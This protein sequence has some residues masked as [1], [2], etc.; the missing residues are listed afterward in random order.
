ME[1]NSATNATS[2]FGMKYTNR[3]LKY[4]KKLIPVALKEGGHEST[5][6]AIKLLQSAKLRNDGL[7]I[8]LTPPGGMD[9]YICRALAKHSNDKFALFT[10]LDLA[11][12]RIYTRELS[13]NNPNFFEELARK[14]ASNEFVDES[15]KKINTFKS[16][17]PKDR[18][19]CRFQNITNI[20]EDVKEEFVEGILPYFKPKNWKQVKSLSTFIDTFDGLSIPAPL[21]EWKSYRPTTKEGK[22]IIKGLQKEIDKL[23]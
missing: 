16:F 12:D 15:V 23:K 7:I 4:L 9:S 13:P 11:G 20:L 14:L 8:D 6:N 22:E 1:I 21:F 5:S 19:L 10:P 3:S 18:F 2:S 17:S